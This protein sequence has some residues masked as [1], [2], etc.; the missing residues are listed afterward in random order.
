MSQNRRSEPLT[1]SN[2]RLLVRVDDAGTSLA[3][4]QGCERAVRDGIAR[5]IEV[6]MPGAWVCDAA[7]RFSGLTGVDIGIHLTLTSE[8]DR[9]KWRPLTHAPTLV[10]GHGFFRP[11]FE[12]SAWNLAEVEAEF[13]AQ[14]ELGTRLFPQASHI[15]SHMTRHFEDVD[16][17]LGEM[18]RSLAEHF[19]LRD[20][21]LGTDGLPRVVG[22][23]PFPRDAE[24]RVASFVETVSNLA[25]GT[26]IFVDHPAVLSD[27]MRAQG[28]DGYEDV[29][30]D[31]AACLA[32]LTDPRVADAV[33]QHDVQLI[34]YRDLD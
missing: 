29:A 18:V 11:R 13:R 16:P 14:I 22:Y 23:P 27:E 28:H 17:R 25:S 24:A 2:A 34:S 12:A 9:V 7:S 26:S 5:S 20:D 3:A 32:V 33:R 4:N 6:M 31:R 19:E 15:S 30:E 8:W 1:P 10:D 21:R